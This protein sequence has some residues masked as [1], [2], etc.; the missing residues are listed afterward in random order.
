MTETR[1][2]RIFN[3]NKVNQHQKV[4]QKAWSQQL[5]ILF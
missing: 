2:F 3:Q 4:K 5:H 1:E